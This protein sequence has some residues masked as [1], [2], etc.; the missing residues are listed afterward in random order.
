MGKCNI[1]PTSKNNMHLS[2]ARSGSWCIVEAHPAYHCWW[3]LPED[4]NWR[5]AGILDWAR[6]ELVGLPILIRVV[7]TTE[8]GLPRGCNENTETMK[9]IER[10]GLICPAQSPFN[11]LEKCI[12]GVQCTTWNQFHWGFSPSTGLIVCMTLGGTH[13][14]YKCGKLPESSESLFSFQVCWDKQTR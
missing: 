9:E 7:N 1:F 4:R 13:Q 11:S 6:W 12:T 5:Q 2:T 3:V 8:Y 10:V 14:S